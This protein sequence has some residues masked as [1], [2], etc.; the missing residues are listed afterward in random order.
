MCACPFPTCVCACRHACSCTD[1]HTF[2][3]ILFNIVKLEEKNK[4][5]ATAINFALILKYNTRA[6]EKWKRHQMIILFHLLFCVPNLI[7]GLAGFR[8]DAVFQPHCYAGRHLGLSAALR[9]SP[10][11]CCFLS[12]P[13]GGAMC[14]KQMIWGCHGQM[15][16]SCRKS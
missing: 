13:I 8:A 16:W 9:C 11:S 5:R 2:T 14:T 4:K 12:S 15:A 7:G 1:T 3:R 10:S 6:L